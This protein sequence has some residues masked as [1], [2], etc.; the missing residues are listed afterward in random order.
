MIL[1]IWMEKESQILI[2]LS[3]LKVVQ[4]FFCR[5]IYMKFFP[6]CGTTHASLRTFFL[7]MIGKQQRWVNLKKAK[8]DVGL[9][10]VGISKYFFKAHYLSRFSAIPMSNIYT[11]NLSLNWQYPQIR[12]LP[13]C[14]LKSWRFRYQRKFH[15]I[16]QNI[17]SL[18]SHL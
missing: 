14:L 16:N 9:P 13:L 1:V 18:E 10:L 11:V 2:L 3:N 7:M 15:L 12:G 6:Y 5:G 8:T 17:K 4:L